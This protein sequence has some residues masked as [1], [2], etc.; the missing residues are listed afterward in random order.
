MGIWPC[1]Q[2]LHELHLVVT[3]PSIL[4]FLDPTVSIGMNKSI[5]LYGQV[6]KKKRQKRELTNS[7]G[8][9]EVEAEDFFFFSVEEGC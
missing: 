5:S 3:F 9:E 4:Q 7:C 6:K 2:S 1:S 8:I